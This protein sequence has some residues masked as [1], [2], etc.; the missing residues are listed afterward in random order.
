M[1]RGKPSSADVP[2]QDLDQL[3]QDRSKGALDDIPIFLR[4]FGP[5]DQTK[6]AWP[7][8]TLRLW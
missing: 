3:R 2:T 7:Y 5:Q 1:L 8:L 6:V 4:R